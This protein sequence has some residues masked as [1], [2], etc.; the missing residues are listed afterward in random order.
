[1]ARIDIICFFDMDL[2]R[3][4]TFVKIAELKSFTKAAQE[5]YLTQP[6]VSKQVVDLERYFGVRLIDRTKRNVALTR[7]GEI[8]AGYGKDFLALRKEM[9]DAMEA[10]KGL[11]KGLV[12][13]GAS[14]IPGVYIL[15]QALKTFRERYDGIQIKLIVSDSK[16][17][18]DK[19]EQGEIDVGFVGAKNE[20]KKL[21]YKRLI[22]DTLVI[23]APPDYPDSITPHSLKDYPFIMR[24]QGSG[25]RNSFQ[26]ALKKMGM[27]L[28]A[29]LRI[30]AELT[31]TEAIK[32]AV[33]NG[34]GI[35]CISQ[36]A[37]SNDIANGQLK[38]MT[39]EG[40]R[41][42]KRSFY[43]VTRKGRTL[44]PQVK[45]LTEIIDKRRKHDKT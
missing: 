27:N 5:L 20:T 39:I 42:L 25:T 31:D 18:M 10:F 41:D 22:D 6:T 13:V 16:D 37:V 23:I 35:S 21:E 33:K 1:M 4:E 17:I 34:M 15:P 12:A 11:K 9:I 40:M 38:I 19:M 7:A 28:V 8:L 29:D 30:V 45:A 3:L 14:N 43:V 24:E 32:E 36:R 2:R 44:L 26:S